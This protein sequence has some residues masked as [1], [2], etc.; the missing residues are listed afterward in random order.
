VFGSVVI[1]VFIFQFDVLLGHME[2]D[3]TRKVSSQPNC[4]LRL[5]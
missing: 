3:G 5:G 2:A 4:T 1:S